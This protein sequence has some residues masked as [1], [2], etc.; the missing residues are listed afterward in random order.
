MDSHLDLNDF[1]PGLPHTVGPFTSSVVI[2]SNP[3]QGVPVFVFSR[4]RRAIQ[5]IK[6]MWAS[7][8]PLRSTS[9]HIIQCEPMGAR[10]ELVLGRSI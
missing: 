1:D 4:S 6:T 2:S 9:S 10:V 5:R 8:T 7:S 3:D